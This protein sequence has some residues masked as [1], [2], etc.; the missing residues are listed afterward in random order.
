MGRLYQQRKGTWDFEWGTLKEQSKAGTTAEPPAALLTNRLFP[1]RRRGAFEARGVSFRV[2]FSRIR[3]CHDKTV[4][5]Q[6]TQRTL[7]ATVIVFF[8]TASIRTGARNGDAA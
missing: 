1:R 5:L 8:N 2:R 4:R 3:R 6:T 7:T